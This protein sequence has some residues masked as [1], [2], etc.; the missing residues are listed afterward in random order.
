MSS[1]G[2]NITGI[3]DESTESFRKFKK[4]ADAI[5][6]LKMNWSAK[7][8]EKFDEKL[9]VKQAVQVRKE[10]KRLDMLDKLKVD[11]P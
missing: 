2:A 3:V 9:S 10:G 6:E 1:L 11:S 8:K 7:M 4:E 5:Q